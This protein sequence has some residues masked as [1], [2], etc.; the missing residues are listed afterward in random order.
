[1]RKNVLRSPGLIVLLF[2]RLA[3]AASPVPGDPIAID[4]G[5]VAGTVL[6][7]GLHAYLGIPFGAPPVGDLRWHEPVPAKPWTGIYD[8]SATKPACAQAA[9][10][11][12][13]GG[14]NQ[15]SEDCLYL[16][17]WVPP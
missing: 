10:G 1:M 2:C 13:A 5:K 7:N 12:Q 16:N 3:I 8:A 17:V 6:D 11:N 9:A 14:A 15:S 4:T